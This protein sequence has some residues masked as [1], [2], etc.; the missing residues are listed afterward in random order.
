MKS[1][2]KRIFY[3]FGSLRSHFGVICIILTRLTPLAAKGPHI[4]HE[5]EGLAQ[6]TAKL[7]LLAS[8]D[9]VLNLCTNGIQVLVGR[10]PADS[11]N[12]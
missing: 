2:T 9:Q 4:Q 10:N 6:Y 5:C 8:L 1:P 12:R 11:V 3:H 7:E